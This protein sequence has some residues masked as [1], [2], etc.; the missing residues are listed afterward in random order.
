MGVKNI[1]Y[2]ASVYLDTNI[3][4]YA[5]EDFSEYSAIIKWIFQL[6]DSGTAKAFTSEFTLAEVLVQPFSVKN[7]SLISLYQSLIQDSEVLSVPPI[8][9]PILENAALIRAQSTSRISLADAIHLATANI[10]KC[11][12]VITND[13]RLARNKLPEIEI[14]LL[15]DF[16]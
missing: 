12:F 15:D 1:P 14:Y 8:T 16:I 6:F 3:F 11:Q 7:N 13:K 5:L 2:G 9:R 4:I 10:H